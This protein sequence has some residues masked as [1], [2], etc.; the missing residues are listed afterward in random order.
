[1]Q[2]LPRERSKAEVEDCAGECEDKSENAELG[3]DGPAPVRIGELREEREE[4]QEPVPASVVLALM[5]E[6]FGLWWPATGRRAIVAPLAVL[7]LPAAVLITAGLSAI[8]AT[9]RT[10]TTASG[11]QA[12]LRE[13]RVH[14]LRSPPTASITVIAA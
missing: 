12:P 2:G 11:S 8:I 4:D 5:Q 3:S 14:R 1:V 13:R 9:Q 6:G 10:P 7:L